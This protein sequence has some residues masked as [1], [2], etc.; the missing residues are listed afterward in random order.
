MLDRNAPRRLLP[1]VAAAALIACGGSTSPQVPVSS[2][3][4]ADASAPVAASPAST[5]GDEAALVPIAADDPQRG[6][7][8][9]PVTLVLF[10]DFQ[11]PFCSRFET[12]LTKLRQSYGPDQLRIVWK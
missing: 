6:A 3:A 4:G 7:P 10:S 1:V 8:D 11:C 2:G 9:A 12:T 5:V